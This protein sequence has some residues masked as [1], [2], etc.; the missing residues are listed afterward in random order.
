LI[1]AHI[2]FINVNSIEPPKIASI[3][4]LVYCL[5]SH[6]KEKERRYQIY[7]VYHDHR[8]KN[9]VKK[10]LYLFCNDMFHLWRL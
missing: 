1:F 8:N 3:S 7:T 2:N 4:V 10:G 5:L 9:C 6:F